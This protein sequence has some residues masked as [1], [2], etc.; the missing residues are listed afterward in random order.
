MKK[1][2]IVLLLV[3]HSYSVLAV[4]KEERQTIGDAI[5]STLGDGCSGQLEANAKN[6][7]I[8]TTAVPS[9]ISTLALYPAVTILGVTLGA[10]SGGGGGG[11]LPAG[12]MIGAVTIASEVIAAGPTGLVSTEA[13]RDQNFQDAAYYLQQNGFR[14]T[15]YELALE[16]V[17]QVGEQR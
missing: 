17:S 8:S 7:A 14:G 11:G 1:I 16:I 3:V 13:L 12:A 5:F 2:I 6:L 9:C 10:T 15:V 4:P